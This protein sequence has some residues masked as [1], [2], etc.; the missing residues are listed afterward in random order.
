[1]VDF[2]E[3]D[4]KLGDFVLFEDEQLYYVAKFAEL[5]VNHVVCDLQHQRVV[6]THQQH[7]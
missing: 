2:S 1:L 5:V 3:L 7:P 6:H 4:E